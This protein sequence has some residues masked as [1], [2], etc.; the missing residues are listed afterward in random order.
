M[1]C[2]TLKEKRGK[3]YQQALWLNQIVNQ[4]PLKKQWKQKFAHLVRDEEAS[5]EREQK[6]ESEEA[7]CTAAEQPQEQEEEEAEIMTEITLSPELG[8][9]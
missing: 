7:A 3:T 2:S 9:M 5:P 1:S 4:A 6:K 8:D